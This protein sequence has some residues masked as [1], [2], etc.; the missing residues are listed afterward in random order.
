[1]ANKGLPYSYLESK[2][3]VELLLTHL[4]VSFENI[5]LFAG[6]EGE[7]EARRVYP[8][9]QLWATSRESRTALFHAGQVIRY[10]KLLNSKRCGLHGGVRDFFAV[11]V[12]HAA[13]TF[14][15]FGI[16]NLKP[17]YNGEK[18]QTTTSDQR[19]GVRDHNACSREELVWL[20]IEENAATKLFIALRRGTPCFS[21]VTSTG[22]EEIAM[23][24]TAALRDPQRV[25]RATVQILRGTCGNGIDD[26]P[27]PPLVD[28]LSQLIMELGDAAKSV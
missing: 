26:M 14:W 20:D 10:A 15:T 11:A 27:P 28:N 17:G 3:L 12:Y 4:H 9:L 22:V 6:R 19:D 25:M 16:L 7:E 21:T 8:S 13:L 2:M 5:Q 1:M 24:D 18:Q 23:K